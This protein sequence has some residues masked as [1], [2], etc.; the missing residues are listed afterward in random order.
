V[1]SR[2]FNIPIWLMGLSNLSFGFF[3][4]ILVMALPQM[5]AARH[6][7]EQRIATVIAI[8]VAAAVVVF[9]LG[10]LLDV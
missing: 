2:S 6:V 1:K 3:N 5:L 8:V 10:P 4:G 7:S 9:P